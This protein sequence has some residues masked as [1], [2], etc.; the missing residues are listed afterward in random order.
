MIDTPDE[1]KGLSQDELRFWRL[2]DERELQSDGTED[3]TLA[4]GHKIT[5][6]IPLPSTRQYEYCRRVC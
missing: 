5:S 2:I 1:L 4:C 6:I 3:I